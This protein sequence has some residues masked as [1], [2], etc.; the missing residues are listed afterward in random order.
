[1]RQQGSTSARRRRPVALDLE[2]PHGF[3]SEM[4]LIGPSAAPSKVNRV[5]ELRRLFG[6]FAELRHYYA[7]RRSGLFDSHTKS[8]GHDVR[9]PL[10][11][12]LMHGAARGLSPH[13]LFDSGWYLARNQD[14]KSGSTNPL[15]HYLREGKKRGYDPN[16]YFST[17]WY[18]DHNNDVVKS[19][20]HPLTHYFKYGAAEGRDPSAKFNTKWYITVNPDVRGRSAPAGPAATV[21]A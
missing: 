13:P 4:R 19:D 7:V 1:M 6:R 3:R 8:L 21:P 12:F 20:M 2:S 9:F 16:P 11:H 5:S 14:V 17:R 18:L 15:I 10:V